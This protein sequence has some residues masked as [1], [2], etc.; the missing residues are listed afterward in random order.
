MDNN[1]FTCGKP[2]RKTDSEIVQEI[3][4][5]VANA[6]HGYEHVVDVKLSERRIGAR[7]RVGYRLLDVTIELE[8]DDA[9]LA[10]KQ[11]E[12]SKQKKAKESGYSGAA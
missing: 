1:P 3:A 6:L 9:E 12:R 8:A 10:A 7:F 4:G 5:K 2:V 11:A